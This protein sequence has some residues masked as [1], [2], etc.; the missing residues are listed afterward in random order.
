MKQVRKQYLVSLGLSVLIAMLLGAALMLLTGHNPIEAYGIMFSGA[1]G[2][3]TDLGDTLYKST[4]L[5]ITGLATAVASQSGIFNVGGEGQMYLG[6]LA[7]AWLGALL[8]GTS[9]WLAIP[10]CLCIAGLAGALW[11]LIPAL[12]KVKLKI[13]EVITT[14]LM[15]T[16]ALK[17]CS[18]MSN[19]PLKTTERGI[20][21][22]TQSI[23]K[24]F[25]FA[26]IDLFSGSNLTTAVVLIVFIIL[27]VWYMMNRTTTGFEMKLTGQ[28]ESFA[29]FSGLSAAR[30]AVL[31]ML[32][33]GAMCGLLGMFETFGVQRR[34]RMDFS[35]EFYFDGMLVAMIMQYKPLGIVLMS[36]FFGI[37]MTGGQR[38]QYIGVSSEL[39]E[40]I[41]SFIIF[42]MAAE[43]GLLGK[44][45]RALTG[46]A[47]KK[48]EVKT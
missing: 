14:I 12:L 25:R 9:P 39:V 37:L 44:V 32:I 15:N 28:N 47:A 38:M 1:L 2:S 24:A 26:S 36:F 4:Q 5:A 40:I 20:N 6:A 23:S 19:G 11:A 3:M 41:Q 35:S 30:L 48:Q 46:G 17:F 45:S 13:N 8:K 18:Y 22:G 31:G 43:S 34:F 10:A 42:L 33:S 7:S 27:L 16:I 29:R 21:Q